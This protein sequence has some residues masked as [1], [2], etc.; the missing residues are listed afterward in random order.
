MSVKF[1]IYEFLMCIKKTISVAGVDIL[2][3]S[4]LRIYTKMI[5]YHGS[6][7]SIFGIT[8]LLII[9]VMN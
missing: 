2:H 7:D 1:K 9:V 6:F 5:W 3:Y 4:L 8:S